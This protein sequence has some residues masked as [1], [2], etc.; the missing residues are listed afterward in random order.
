ML[1]KLA[2]VV[3]LVAISGAVWAQHH[4]QHLRQ[5]LSLTDAQVERLRSLRMEQRKEGVRR[6]AELRVK[7]MELKELLTAKDVDEKAIDVKVKE[8]SDLQ[9]ASLRARVASRLAFRKVLT[10]E[11]Q[12]KFRELREQGESRGFERGRGHG[13]R[14]GEAQGGEP[15]DGE[16][17]GTDSDLR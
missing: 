8:V 2:W 16:P 12:Q 11:Q 13:P 4:P 1:T 14:G 6:H 15:H 17:H 9:A 7:R 5:A 10:P 3:G